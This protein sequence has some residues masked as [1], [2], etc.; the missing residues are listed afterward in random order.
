MRE[1]GLG[2]ASTFPRASEQRS[3]PQAFSTLLRSQLLTRHVQKEYWY[4]YRMSS[5]S[6]RASVSPPLRLLDRAPL[7]LL[8]DA[9][10]LV[11]ATV[12]RPGELHEALPLS[13]DATDWLASA[14]ASLGLAVDVL[15]SVL[16]E[17]S[18][19]ARD[20]GNDRFAHLEPCQPPAVA[21]PMSAAE[22]DYLRA[23]T[24][25]RRPHASRKGCASQPVIAVPV[26][27]VGRL[28]T[29]DAVG[30]LRD[31]VPERALSWEIAAVLEGRTLA[32]CVL[33]RAAR[34]TS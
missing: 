21:R 34:V 14:S 11:G 6:K 1:F 24:L 29:V 30:A 3:Q 25:A 7:P 33:A 23:L 26:R 20:V 9:T 8:P 16:L 19:T 28:L 17:A 18:L 10:K 31:V 22:G 13:I 5:R 32:E 15:G 27:L 2:R 12:R 4:N